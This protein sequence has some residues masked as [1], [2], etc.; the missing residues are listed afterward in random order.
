MESS[1]HGVDK[2]NMTPPPNHPMPHALVQAQHTARAA[3]VYEAW[4]AAD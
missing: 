2:S 4:K 1:S 3:H